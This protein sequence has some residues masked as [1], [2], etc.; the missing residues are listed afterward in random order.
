MRGEMMMMCVSFSLPRQ[1]TAWQL[2]AAVQAGSLC[3]VMCFTLPPLILAKVL[4]TPLLSK[5]AIF[6]LGTS[7]I[8][9]AA[10]SFLYSFLSSSFFQ[11]SGVLQSHANPAVWYVYVSTAPKWEAEARVLTPL[12]TGVSGGEVERRRG[13]EADRRATPIHSQLSS[14]TS[15]YCLSK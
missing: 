10:F 5:Y 1:I 11:R 13:G 15:N 6:W 9:Q 8:E 12:T 14:M 3:F 7:T 2:T 4:T